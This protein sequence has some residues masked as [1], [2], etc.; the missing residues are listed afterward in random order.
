MLHDVL[1]HI[2]TQHPDR[3]ALGGD[4]KDAETLTYAQ[5]W[6]QVNAVVTALAARGVT[7]GDRVAV[8]SGNGIDAVVC[9]WAIAASG[10]INVFLNDQSPPA[11][12]RQILDDATPVFTLATASMAKKR[13]AINS[14]ENGDSGEVAAAPECL[15]VS[16]YPVVELERFYAEALAAAGTTTP[17]APVTK[18]AMPAGDDAIAAIIYTSGST[19]TPKGVCLTHTNLIEVARMAGDRYAT[20]PSDSYLMVVPLHY[21]HGLMILVT[22]HLRGAAIHFM[23]S[24]V[25]PK[26]VTRRLQ[27]LGVTGFS[28]VPY[29]FTALVERGGLLEADL[30]QLRWMGVTGGTCPPERLQ[31]IRQAQP[32]IE[33]HISYGQT[34]CS[35]RITA[36]DPA[37]IDTKPDSVGEVAEGLIVEFLGEDGQPVPR[38][39]LGELVVSGPTVMHGYWNDPESTRRVIDEQGRLH[40]G[41]LAYID[42]DGDVYIKGRIQAM[43]K[44][45]GERIFPEELEAILN[46]S[47]D[48]SDVAV[49]GVEDERY[50]QRVEAHVCILPDAT[51]ALA[52]GSDAETAML[53][54][55]KAHC[56]VHVPL[57]KAPKV[58]HLWQEFPLKA[59]GKTDKQTLMKNVLIRQQAAASESESAPQTGVDNSGASDELHSQRQLKSG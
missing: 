40:T 50:G 35:P 52:P 53:Q 21:I 37:R 17:I 12:L 29:H 49:V 18:T 54:R 24:F 28:G 13:F 14:R 4:G 33:L 7:P 16:D 57:V 20:V 9:F 44:S 2:A 19:G 5:L 6:Q 3:I 39:E 10:A 47:A 59:N 27:Q 31:Q 34:E 55:I 15:P 46:L 42:A 51:D 43:I 38:G 1:Q 30:P 56:L 26:L 48:V 41:D 25:F 23:N 11:A 22:M 45:A 32:S 8:L 36:L 58:Y